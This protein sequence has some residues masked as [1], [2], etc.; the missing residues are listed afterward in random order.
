M[1]RRP[2]LLLL[3]GYFPP[4]RI[5]SG[6]I[7]PWNLARCL[8][9]LG[10]DVTVVTPKISIW[11]LSNLDN[12]ECIKNDIEKM[13]I[14][15][16]Y[17]DHLLKCLA[18]WRYKLPQGKLFWFFGGVLRVVTRSLGI[19]NWI[20][21]VPSAL[22]ACRKLKPADVDVILATGAPFWGFEVAYRLS[23]RLNKPYIMDYRDL[24]TNN[25][26]SPINRKWVMKQERKL[27]KKSAAVTI[28]SPIS[29]TVLENK[30][31]ITGK[32]FT[33]TNGYDINDIQNIQAKSFDHF[34]IIFS[35]SLISAKMTLATIF[36]VLRTIK[37]KERTPK[38]KFHYFGVNTDVV[39]NEIAEWGLQKDSVIHGNCP[40]KEVLSYAKGASL[41][42]VLSSD[43]GVPT[44]E[45]KGVIPGKIFELIGMEASI[46]SIV[47]KGSAVE[48]V[49]T[50]VGVKS[51]SHDEVEKIANFIVECM[52]GHEIK[53]INKEKYS[54]ETLSKKFDQLL[55]SVM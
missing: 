53:V 6:S 2:K 43:A 13:G 12:V 26:W 4:V 42:V 3:A 22:H 32:V 16:I 11:D 7:R 51:F 5:S 37:Q 33:I 48:S 49:L 23:K 46:L 15:M 18:P 41:N 29:G 28:V 27:L 50:E 17:T 24:W 9:D 21:W 36:R 40:R 35:G 31:G 20:G 44:I 10:W 55:R 54:W 34:S 25:P 47:P 8:I 52:N 19:Q 39:K 45:D 38:W 1:T 14:R 30:Y